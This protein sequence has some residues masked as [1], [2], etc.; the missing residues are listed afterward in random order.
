MA[1]IRSVTAIKCHQKKPSLHSYNPA[2]KNNKEDMDVHPSNQTCGIF[3]LY[4][5][6][7]C[8]LIVKVDDY[9]KYY[10]STVERFMVYWKHVYIHA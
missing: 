2:N 5:V 4:L 8:Q 10:S 1:M 3:L 7:T 6:P 9:T